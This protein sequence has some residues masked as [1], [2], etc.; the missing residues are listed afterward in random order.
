MR[1]KSEVGSIGED[2]ACEYLKERGYRIIDRNVKHSWGELDIVAKNREGVLVFIEVKTLQGQREPYRPEDHY[3]YAK[4]EKT[5]RAAQ[6]FAGKNSNLLSEKSGWRID[7]VA[8]VI[9]NPMLTDYRKDCDI[10]HY[11]NNPS[12][13]TNNANSS[14]SEASF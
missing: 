5:K 4:S 13:V 3:N 1:S 12:S 10:R 8:I 7:L 11:E 14:N 6:L 2:I 9:N